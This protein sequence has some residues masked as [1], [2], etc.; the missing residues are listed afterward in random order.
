M[1]GWADTPQPGECGRPR[2][3]TRR[4]WRQGWRKPRRRSRADRQEQG[5][6]ARRD[7]TCRQQPSVHKASRRSVLVREHVIR[8]C[9]ILTYK[10][11]VKDAST[12]RHLLRHARAC[13]FVW[14]H[15]CGAQRHAMKWQ[16]KWPSAF[17]LVKLCTGAGKELGLHSD[18]VQ[19]ICRD[20]A[21]RRDA[22]RRC[23]HVW[24]SREIG[25]EIKAGCFVQDARGRW[26]VAF[27]CEVPDGLPTG[28]GEI[29]I[30]L[31][32][33]KL[34]ACS[35]G[36]VVPALRHYRRYEAALAKARRARNKRRV[37][38]IHAKIANARR[39]H[40]HEQSTRI[41][42][43]NRLIAVGNVNAIKLVK[44]RMAKSVL[45]A[46]WSTFRHQLRY[47]AGRHEARYVETD[48]RNT[49][50]TCSACGCVG[51]PKGIAGLR[52]RS[53]VCCNCGVGHDRDLNA[54]VNI[55]RRAG[56]SASC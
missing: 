34:A 14:N 28:A 7:G 12:R 31:G 20:F 50:A 43:E 15:C 18:T 46:S 9:V 56:T 49:S 53:W 3:C 33:K 25:G 47:K 30:D 41:A 32:L 54:A 29:G 1:R 42:R 35:D 55:L 10:Y 23:P 2:R 17:D 8:H 13:N 52:M 45:D 39:H 27:Q 36:D 19:S 38:A 4:A 22:V 5:H 37:A 6:T 11:R 40:L 48:E 44:T 26:Y 21:A 24:L 16:R 51:G